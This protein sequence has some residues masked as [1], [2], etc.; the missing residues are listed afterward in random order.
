[1]SNDFKERRSYERFEIEIEVEIFDM[2]GASREYL[3]TA[4]LQDISG[5]GARF[6]SKNPERYSIGQR[7]FVAIVLPGTESRHPNMQGKATVIWVGDD[8]ESEDGSGIGLRM[9]D[10]LVFD[11]LGNR[12]VSDAGSGASG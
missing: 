4:T 11:H 6:V 12:E 2:D 10:L 9:D 3:E 8:G 5:G 7:L 1:M